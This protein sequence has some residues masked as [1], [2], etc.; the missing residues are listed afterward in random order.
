MSMQTAPPAPLLPL[1]LTAPA[2]LVM[3]GMVPLET[4]LVRGRGMGRYREAPVSQCVGAAVPFNLHAREL[5][6]CPAFLW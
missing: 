2:T 6:S 3:E 5:L 1:A 4:A